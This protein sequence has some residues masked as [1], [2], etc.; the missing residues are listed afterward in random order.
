M[1]HDLLMYRFM[2]TVALSVVMG[3]ACTMAHDLQMFRFMITLA[4]SVVM[5]KVMHNGS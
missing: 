3:K 2:M 5:G 4:F 1:A